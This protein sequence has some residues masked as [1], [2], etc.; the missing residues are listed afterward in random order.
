LPWLKEAEPVLG[1]VVAGDA[2]HER[3]RK[4]LETVR[5]AGFVRMFG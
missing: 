4:H 1:R 5:R 3:Y 2:A